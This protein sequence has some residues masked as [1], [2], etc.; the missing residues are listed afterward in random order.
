M[1]VYDYNWNNYSFISAGLPKPTNQALRCDWPQYSAI[2]KQSFGGLP[3]YC[4]MLKRGVDCTVFVGPLQF[5]SW[6]RTTSEDRHN[7]CDDDDDDVIAWS[8][9]VCLSVFRQTKHLMES[10]EWSERQ[11]KPPRPHHHHDNH[12][13]SVNPSVSQQSASFS[14]TC[15][16]IPAKCNSA[17]RSVSSFSAHLE[18]DQSQSTQFA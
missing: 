12:Q 2:L 13:L 5:S 18:H 11:V 17:T 3:K 4:E 14:S 16:L 8:S 6:Q 7:F 1:D 10:A 15:L 9:V